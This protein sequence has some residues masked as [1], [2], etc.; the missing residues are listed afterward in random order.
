MVRQNVEALQ[1]PL[2][3]QKLN[4]LGYGRTMHMDACHAPFIGRLVDDLI[5]AGEGCR[6][7]QQHAEK[8]NAELQHK[9][10]KVDINIPDFNATCSVESAFTTGARHI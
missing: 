7:L 8:Q 9:T 3:L 6:N 2:L 1:L 4:A 5:S 10:Q